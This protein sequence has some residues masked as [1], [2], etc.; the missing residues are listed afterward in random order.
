VLPVAVNEWA[1]TAVAVSPA[2]IDEEYVAVVA[3]LSAPMVNVSPNTLA[4]EGAIE[5]IE[6]P[7]A[8]IADRATRLK[9]VGFDITF[10]S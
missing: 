8:A 3:E 9:N 2:V 7:I 10:L 4:C 5:S 6:R 1:R